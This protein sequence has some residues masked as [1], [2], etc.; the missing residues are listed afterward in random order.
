[1]TLIDLKEYFE[2][3]PEKIKFDYGVSEPFS[4]RGRYDEVAFE[5]LDQGM[6]R[7]QIL[8]NIKFAYIGEFS[9]YKGGKYEYDDFTEI[10]FEVDTS[11]YTDGGYVAN[12]IAKLENKSPNYSQEERLIKLAFSNSID[13]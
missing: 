4:W 10:H 11:S 6:T 1:M 5:I 7:E 12:W 8:H 13:Y 9:G 2:K 3:F